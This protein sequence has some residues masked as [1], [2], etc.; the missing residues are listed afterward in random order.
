MT[1]PP[2]GFIA[3]RF[4]IPADEEHRLRDLDRFGVLGTSSDIHLD[5]LVELAR[6]IFAVPMAAI[7]LVTSDRQWFL[8]QTYDPHIENPSA[9]GVFL[10]V[11]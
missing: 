7:S 9:L 8:A 1:S 4:P 11:R 3:N 5:R 6:L 10:S 2:S